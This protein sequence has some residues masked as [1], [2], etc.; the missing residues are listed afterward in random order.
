[1]TKG[2]DNTMMSNEYELNRWKVKQ[3]DSVVDEGEMSEFICMTK[4][5]IIVRNGHGCEG[6]PYW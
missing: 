6:C 4:N 5:G 3:C 2:N 1:M